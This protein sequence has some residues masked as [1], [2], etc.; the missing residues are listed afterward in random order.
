MILEMGVMKWAA[1]EGFC[2][3]GFSVSVFFSSGIVRILI[4][5]FWEV[6]NAMFRLEMLAPL[7]SAWI[8][9][10]LDAVVANSA[11]GCWLL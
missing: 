4:L 11:P 8:L 9:V 7:V 2:W 10:L 5:E 6:Q 1:L 3:F